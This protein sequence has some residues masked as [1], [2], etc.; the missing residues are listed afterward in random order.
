MEGN[1]HFY[2]AEPMTSLTCLFLSKILLVEMSCAIDCVLI[3]QIFYDPQKH[4]ERE[5]ETA[6]GGSSEDAVQ[7]LR[8][9]C[10]ICE[11]VLSALYLSGI[12][13]VV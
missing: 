12:F 2:L 10:G 1:E 9:Y 4:R 8:L 13:W 6:A 3:P 7:W 11:R 5:E